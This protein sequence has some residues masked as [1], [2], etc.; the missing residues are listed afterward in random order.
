[1]RGMLPERWQSAFFGA[2]ASQ[3]PFCA[4][5]ARVCYRVGSLHLSLAAAGRGLILLGKCCVRFVC[6]LTCPFSVI[7]HGKN[8][9]VSD[10][11]VLTLD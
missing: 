4:V 6:R 10:I 7:I 8:P 9:D 5:R 1:M 11:L 3:G 2:F